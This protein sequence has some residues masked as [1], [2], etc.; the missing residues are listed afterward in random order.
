M[1]KGKKKKDKRAM[2]ESADLLSNPDMHIGRKLKEARIAA[3]YTAL[4]V[5][6]RVGQSR[7]QVDKYENGTSE[8]TIARLLQYAHVLGVGLD[9]FL[10]DAILPAGNAYEGRKSTLAFVKLVT[11]PRVPETVKTNVRAM[12]KAFKPGGAD[13]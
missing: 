1:G 10:E 6:E 11:D 8:I 3:G 12:L 2:Q 9:W 4:Q 13:L 7:Q 5:A